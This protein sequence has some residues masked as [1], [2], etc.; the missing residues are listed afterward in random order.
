MPNGPRREDEGSVGTQNAPD[1]A[2]QTRRPRLYR[3]LLHNDDF[4]PMEFVVAVLQIVFHRSEIEAHTI[5]LEAH[6]TGLAVAGVYTFEIAETKVEQVTRLA[7][8][9]GFPLLSTMEPE[10]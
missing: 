7:A 3:V 6:R 4:T 8:E 2:T 10:T 5:M 9:S 1:S